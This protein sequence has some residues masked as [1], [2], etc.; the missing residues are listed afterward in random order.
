MLY[1]IELPEEAGAAR[2]SDVAILGGSALFLD[3]RG[4]R[5]YAMTA[6]DKTL[7]LHAKI[8][9]V[10]E[11]ASIAPSGDAVI[12]IAHGKGISRL[13][14]SSHTT[15]PLSAG[16]GI[17]LRGLEWIRE[18]NHTLVGIRTQPNGAYAVVR[19]RLNQRGTTATALEVIDAASA[20]VASINGDVLYYLAAS[21]GGGHGVRRHT[22]R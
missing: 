4:R 1:T 18:F 9:D 3:Q 17:D 20:R 8:D 12:Y 16:R 21:P 14:L 6:D 11:P 10:S 13:N 19:I 22:L 2:F 7:R 15:A 5:I